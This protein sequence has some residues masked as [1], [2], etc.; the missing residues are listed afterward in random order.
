M[1]AD[2][3]WHMYFVCWN[4]ARMIFYEELAGA[5]CYACT[6]RAR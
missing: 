1:V 3:F 4:Q 2:D 5:I 6:G